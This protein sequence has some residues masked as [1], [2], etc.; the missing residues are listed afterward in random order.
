MSGSTTAHSSSVTSVFAMRLRH[1]QGSGFWAH[2]CSSIEKGGPLADR[3]RVSIGS[4]DQVVYGWCTNSLEIV[5]GSA[6]HDIQANSREVVTLTRTERISRFVHLPPDL[7][8]YLGSKSLQDRGD[9]SCY[10]GKEASVVILV[11]KGPAKGDLLDLGLGEAGSHDQ[12][13]DAPRISHGEDA[14]CLGVR[15]RNVRGR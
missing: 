2:Q 11:S 14:G 1:T 9:S 8:M 6:R 10:L 13:P 12:L 15:R 3:S 7:R 4:S 5:S